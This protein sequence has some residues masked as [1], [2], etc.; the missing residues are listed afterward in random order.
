MIRRGTAEDF[1]KIFATINDAAIAYKGVI[2]SDR[3]HK[4]YMTKDEL[5]ANR[6]WCAIFMLADNDQIVESWGFRIREM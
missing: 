5:Q 6:E 1:E 3:W 4:P 2:P